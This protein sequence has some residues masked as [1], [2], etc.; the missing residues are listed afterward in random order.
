MTAQQDS[1]SERHYT[2]GISKGAA[3][4][5]EIRTLLG[6]WTPGVDRSEFLERIQQ[7]GALGKQ[8]AYRTKDMVNRVFRPRLLTPDDSAAR[9]LKQFLEEGGANQTLKELLLLYEARSDDLLYDFIKQRFWTLAY[10]GALVFQVEDVLAFFGEA[11]HDGRLPQPWSKQVQV[12]IARGILGALRDFGFLREDKRGR[13]EIVMY[14]MTDA[15]IAYLAHE[16]HF[17]GLPDGTLVGHAD[18]GL[19]GLDRVH[20]LNRLDALGPQA[21]LVVQRAGS[22]VQI[23]W[24]HSSMESVV[25]ALTR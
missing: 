15:G 24:S 22:V 19:F 8:T 17:C 11:A 25:H 12:K 1:T 21:G 13:R 2:V 20:L 3:S 23:T 5:N 14:R 9:A 4:I 16:L 18:W 10:A 6:L 7:T